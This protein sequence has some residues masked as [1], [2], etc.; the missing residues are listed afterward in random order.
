M[1]E[2]QHTLAASAGS[3]SRFAAHPFANVPQAELESLNALQGQFND[4]TRSHKADLMRGIYQTKDGSPY[5]FP[6]VKMARQMLFDDPEWEHEYPASHLG[7]SGACHMGARF[8]RKHNEPYESDPERSVY[9]PAESWVNHPNIFHNAGFSTITLPYYDSFTHSFD[10]DAFNDALKS[11]PSQSIVVLQV[12]GNNPTGCDP[13][14]EQW[15]RLAQTFRAKQHFAFFD[16]SYPG[17][18]SGSVA[19]DCMPIRIFD[20][21]GIPLL[22]AATYGK[23]L[24]LY[25][26]RVGYLCVS[27]PTAEAAVRCEQQM[28]LLARAET[29]AQPR[30]GARLVSNILGTPRLKVQWEEDIYRLA[31]DLADRRKKLKIELLRGNSDHDWEFATSQTGMFL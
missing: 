15:Q 6:S 23:M 10:F 12:C 20:K 2:T 31:D 25:G 22:V 11:A 17:F 8:L 4:D 5:V 9:I 19:K 1:P 16:L 24:G 14:T 21:V 18:A 28:K 3:R 13:S 30:F 27:L 7:G 26:E 29:G